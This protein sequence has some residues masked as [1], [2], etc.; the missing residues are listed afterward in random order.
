MELAREGGV[1]Q[2][3]KMT[4]GTKVAETNIHYPTEGGFIRRWI[5]RAHANP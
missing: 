5:A 2:G 4:V 1:V 3:R